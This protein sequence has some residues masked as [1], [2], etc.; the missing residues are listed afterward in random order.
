MFIAHAKREEGMVSTTLAQLR[1]GC[2]P[3]K[4]RA[5]YDAVDRRIKQAHEEYVRGDIDVG[6]HLRLRRIRHVMHV[7]HEN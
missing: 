3:S 5:K 1:H 2:T 7:F 6:L 4:R